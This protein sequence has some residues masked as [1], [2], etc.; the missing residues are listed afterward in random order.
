MHTIWQYWQAEPAFDTVLTGL[1]VDALV[2]AIAVTAVLLW[3]MKALTVEEDK[4]I[5]RESGEKWRSKL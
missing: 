2:V 5:P 1:E 3:E 4:S